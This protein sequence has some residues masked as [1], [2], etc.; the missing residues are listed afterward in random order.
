MLEPNFQP[1]NRVLKPTWLK[2]V[3]SLPLEYITETVTLYHLTRE[4]VLPNAQPWA[5]NSNEITTRSYCVDT[6]LLQL[7]LNI[8]QIG[9]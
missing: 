4:D 8:L 5:Y 2:S 1:D 7:Q 3:F 6:S 9:M